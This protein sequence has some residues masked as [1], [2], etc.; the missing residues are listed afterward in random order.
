M[1]MLLKAITVIAC[2]IFISFYLVVIIG[3]GVSTG[4]R[5]FFKNKK[6]E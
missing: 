4:L 1:M 3:A 6:G 2:F 5:T